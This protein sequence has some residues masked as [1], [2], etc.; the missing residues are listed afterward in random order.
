MTFVALGKRPEFPFLFFQ[1]LGRTY[2]PL[3]V[4]R[5]RS[6]CFF[7]LEATCW[8]IYGGLRYYHSGLEWGKNQKLNPNEKP[9][10]VGLFWDLDNKPPNAIPP[11]DVSNKLRIT[12]SSFGINPAVILIDAVI[13]GLRSGAGRSRN[14]F[15]HGG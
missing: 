12:A 3:K 5:F 14:S 4:S 6:I 7:S 1:A 13:L 10:R 15:I 9:N 8:H 2:K 11:F